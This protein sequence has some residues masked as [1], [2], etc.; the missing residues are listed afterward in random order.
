MRTIL[1]VEPY[2]V[3][4]SDYINLSLSPSLSLFLSDKRSPVKRRG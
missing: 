2:G 1:L 3:A 4:Y